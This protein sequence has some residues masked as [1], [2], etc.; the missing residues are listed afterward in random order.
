M[1]PNPH[2]DLELT[3]HGAHPDE[4]DLVV[5]AAH[6]RGQTP[7]YMAR[8][9]DRIGL[10]GVAWVLPAAHDSTW[11]PQGFLAPEA[12]NQPRLDQ[13]LEAVDTHLRELLAPGRPPVVALGFS[14][15]ACLLAEHLLRARPRLAGAV[16][17]TG[18]YV[19]PAEKDWTAVPGRRLSDLVVEMFTAQED[20]WVPLHRVEATGAALRALGATVELTVY[21]DPE[22]HLNDDSVHMIR[23]Y[24]RHRLAP[25]AAR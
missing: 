18:G 19:G 20:D 22:H 21:D 13:A 5:Y 9:A 17:H 12:D 23:R 11:Y 10:D 2:L 24:L 7:D 25:R 1:H 16:L 4:A 15:G 6:G 8:V 3:H 14:Q